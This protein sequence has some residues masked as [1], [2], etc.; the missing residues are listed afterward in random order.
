[1]HSQTQ[2][3]S[4][5]VLS[6]CYLFDIVPTVQEDR[7]KAVGGGGEG[8][9][10]GYYVFCRRKLGGVELFV[11]R[12]VVAEHTNQPSTTTREKCGRGGQGI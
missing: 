4:V 5:V 12:S 2:T 8:G 3:A 7:N 11:F 1:M 6:I 9:S 10:G